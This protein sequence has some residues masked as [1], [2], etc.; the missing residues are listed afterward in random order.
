MRVTFAFLP[1][2]RETKLERHIEARCYGRSLTIE[3]DSGKIVKKISAASDQ[4]DDTIEPPSTTRDL[5]GSAWNKSETAQARYE[6]Q[7]QIFV[8]TVIGDVEESG[9]LLRER[10]AAIGRAS[11]GLSCTFR[12]RIGLHAPRL[13]RWHKSEP[14]AWKFFAW[15]VSWLLVVLQIGGCRS[16]LE[17]L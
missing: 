9:F 16:V 4:A 7:I 5:D 17:Q 13:E 14:S 10:S 12:W 15:L 11:L 1:S 3:F 8:A 6:C 2:D